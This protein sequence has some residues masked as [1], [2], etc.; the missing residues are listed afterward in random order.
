M[1]NIVYD[2]PVGYAFTIFLMFFVFIVVS[3][4]FVYKSISKNNYLW[5]PCEFTVRT[6]LSIVSLFLGMI[7]SFLIVTTW[8]SYSAIQN[9]NTD[10]SIA[11]YKLYTL[12]NELPNT[13]N[14]VAVIIE[15]LEYII[16][17]EFKLL[18]SGEITNDDITLGPG[19]MLTQKLQTLIY[20][21]EPNTGQQS[22]IYGQVLDQLNTVLDARVRR[23][24]D[25]KFGLYNVLWW[26]SYINAIMLI[27]MCYLLKCNSLLHYVLVAS[28]AIYV[29]SAIFILLV[30]SYP[31]RSVDGLNADT[32]EAALR[33]IEAN[34]LRDQ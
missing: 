31:Y 15:Y 20:N 33:S 1:L 13:E 32:Y 28:A 23:L 17:V 7:F 14:I 2:L 9:N 25:T 26:V 19:A 21:Y 30:M 22:S 29:S 8:N 24:R 3:G 12:V 4:L 16:N 18:R 11:I 10:E 27:L 5:E 6:F 34:E